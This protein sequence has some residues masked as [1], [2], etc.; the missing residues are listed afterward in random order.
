VYFES[1]KDSG[2]VVITPDG[3]AVCGLN[4]APGNLNPAVDITP[5]VPGGYRVYVASMQPNTVVPGKLTITSDVKAAPATL[6]PAS[7]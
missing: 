1:A 6:A 4:A 5:L 3:K 7:Q 2:L